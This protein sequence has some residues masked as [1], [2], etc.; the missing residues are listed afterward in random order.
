MLFYVQLTQD[1]TI[2]IQRST[3][4]VSLKCTLLIKCSQYEYNWDAV[5]LT[6]SY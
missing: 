1:H 3:R 5:K 6:F 2:S 4:Y